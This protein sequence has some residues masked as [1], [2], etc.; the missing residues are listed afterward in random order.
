MNSIIWSSDGVQLLFTGDGNWFV[1]LN[2]IIDER[3]SFFVSFYRALSF[4][5]FQNVRH[6]PRYLTLA[7]EQAVNHREMLLNAGFEEIAFIDFYEEYFKILQYLDSTTALLNLIDV[8][9]MQFESAR[10]S[11][12][13]AER[14]DYDLYL[15]MNDTMISNA[16]VVHVRFIISAYLKLNAIMYEPFMENGLTVEMFCNQFT[17]AMDR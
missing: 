10:D 7:R 5:F 13:E 9:F 14:R 12:P 6:D 8:D 2:T 17:E 16:V 11:L 3:S 15:V 1:H 4:R